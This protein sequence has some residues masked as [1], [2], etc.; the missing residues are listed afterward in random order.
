MVKDRVIEHPFPIAGRRKIAVDDGEPPLRRFCRKGGLRR[1]AALFQ[2]RVRRRKAPV[3]IRPHRAPKRVQL[4]TH[5]KA[6]PVCI[7]LV[8]ADVDR[9]PVHFQKAVGE[10][11]SRRR[12]AARGLRDKGRL[13]VVCAEFA[14]RRDAQRFPCPHRYRE[15]HFGRAAA[16]FD[17]CGERVVQRQADVVAAAV[18]CVERNVKPA[19]CRGIAAAPE[20]AAHFFRAASDDLEPV[21]ILRHKGG[22]HE[23]IASALVL[24]LDFADR[25]ADVPLDGG[26]EQIFVLPEEV[27][28]GVVAAVE[29][30]L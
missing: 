25:L 18:F 12:A 15:P 21:F 30:A 23:Q 24:A 14:A 10:F 13:R 11:F 27:A 29:G 19:L 5:G 2:R 4:R 9:Q 20:R 7:D 22:A 3:D 6:L 28:L 1:N 8:K 17:A 26:R 16:L